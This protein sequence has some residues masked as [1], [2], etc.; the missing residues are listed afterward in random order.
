MGNLGGLL[1]FGEVAESKRLVVVPAI[2]YQA[3]KNK[4]YPNYPFIFPKES[5]KVEAGDFRKLA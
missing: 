3:K 4:F 5:Y 2:S 1:D